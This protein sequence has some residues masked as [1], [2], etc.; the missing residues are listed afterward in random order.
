MSAELLKRKRK[1]DNEADPDELGDES[2]EIV[3]ALRSDPEFR[4]LALKLKRKGRAS[5]IAEEEGDTLLNTLL[6][7]TVYNLVFFS[8]GSRSRIR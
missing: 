2:Q 4:R 5:L 1:S 6:S 8:T 3:D 7:G